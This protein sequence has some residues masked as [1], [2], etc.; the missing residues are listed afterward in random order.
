L[1]KFRLILSDVYYNGKFPSTIPPY[2]SF[3]VSGMS[4]TGSVRLLISSLFIYLFI[5]F[6]ISHVIFRICDVESVDRGP[7]KNT[8]SL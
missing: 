8:V 3:F 2:F 1:L 6:L 5:F 4:L 7:L